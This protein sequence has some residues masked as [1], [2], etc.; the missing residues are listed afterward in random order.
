MN[1]DFTEIVNKRHKLK[2]KV[3]LGTQNQRNQG[4]GKEDVI[5]KKLLVSHKIR[6]P[7][8]SSGSLETIEHP[9]TIVLKTDALP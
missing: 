3:S 6:K 9:F 1:V 8:C 4:R 2:T 7:Q 5:Y